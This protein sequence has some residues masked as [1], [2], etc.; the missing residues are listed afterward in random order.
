M[1]R[2]LVLR[3]VVT[4]LCAAC[5]AERVHGIAVGR[6][7]W[8]GVVGHSLHALMALAMALMAWPRGADLPTAGPL[9]FFSLAFVWFTAVAVRTA[10]HRR[11]NAY[12]ALMMLAMAWMYAV[13]TDGLLPAPVAAADV[14]GGHHGSSMPAMHLSGVPVVATT[15]AQASASPLVTGLDWLLTIGS[16]VAGAWWLS[17]LLARRRTKPPASGR[18]QLTIATQALMAAGMATMSAAMM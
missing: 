13:M 6:L 17:E 15:P 3:W 18:A 16:A 9:V 12:H 14:G 8:R 5:A 4:A 1:I 10:Q 2:D 7:P 11:S